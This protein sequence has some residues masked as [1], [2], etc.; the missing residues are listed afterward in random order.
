MTHE[1]DEVPPLAPM[2]LNRLV[3]L[4]PPKPLHDAHMGGT[5]KGH[6]K[7]AVRSLKEQHRKKSSS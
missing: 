4:A 1:K 7:D 6:L 3:G 2:V 5:V